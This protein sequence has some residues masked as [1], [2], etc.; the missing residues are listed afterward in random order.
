MPGR[1]LKKRPHRAYGGVF[2]KNHGLGCI[3]FGPLGGD[4]LDIDVG[5]TKK[6]ALCRLISVLGWLWEMM[7]A[8]AD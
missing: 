7:T 3:E 2:T 1:N 5:D 4:L 8:F 6:P